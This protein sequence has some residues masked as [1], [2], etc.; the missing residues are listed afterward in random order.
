MNTRHALCITFTFLLA[1]SGVAGADTGVSDERVV[2]PDGPGSMGGI[3]ENA[4]LDPNMGLMRYGVPVELPEGFAGMTPSVHLG[5]SSGSGSSVVGI[6]WDLSLPLIERMSLRGLPEYTTEDEFAV[7]GGEEL[8][9]VGTEAGVRVYRARFEKGFA[10]YQW[11]D[12]GDGSGGYWTAEYP[13][14]RTDFFGADQDGT[15]VPDARVTHPD[16]GVF[17]YHLVATTDLFGHRISYTYQKHGDTALVDTIGWVYSGSDT[18]RYSVRFLYGDR[19]EAVSTCVPGFELVLDQ[20]L[21]GIEVFSN[22]ERIR[23]YELGYEPYSESGGFTRL[24]SVK[25]YGVNDELHPIQFGFGYSRSLGG[26]CESGCEKPYTVDMGTLPGGVDISTGRATLIDINGDALPDVLNTTDKG[27]HRF[28]LSQIGDGGEP[29]F[30]DS[31][32]ESAS[33]EGGSSFVLNAPGVQV[34]DV[35]GDGFTDII[36]SRVGEALCNRG[37]GDWSA[38]AECMA[39]AT[40]PQLQEDEAGDPNPRHVRFMDFDNDKRIDMIR[41]QTGATEV[42]HN[43]GDAFEQ[44]LVQDIGA[45]FDDSNL[46][47][48]DMNGDGLQDPLQV[49]TGGKIRYRL[50]LGF[51]NWTDWI[52]IDLEGIDESALLNARLEDLNG[53]GLDDVVVV[54]ANQLS[55]AL[56]R[57]GQRFDAFVTLTDAEVEGELPEKTSE[58]TVLFADMNGSGSNDIVWITNTGRVR[59]LELFPVKPNLLS[60]IENGIGHVQSIAYGTS[61][62]EQARDRADDPWRYRLPHAMNVVIATDS[63][64]TLTGGEDG[65]GLHQRTEMLYHHGFYDGVEKA[66]RGYAEVEQ[67][68]LADANL[69]SQEPG[70]TFMSFDVGADDPYYNGLLLE[71]RVF[72]GDESDPVPL[73]RESVEYDDCEVA[74]IPGSGLRLPVRYICETGRQSVMQEGLQES[75]WVTT[76]SEQ[77][78]DGYGNV[79]KSS[80]LG[81]IHLGPPESPAECAACSGSGDT[82]GKPC[83]ASCTGDEQYAESEFVQPGD[84]TGGAWILGSPFRQI[85]YGASDGPRTETL[86][87]YDGEPFQGLA[88][89]ILTQGLVSRVTQRVSASS[90]EVIE[91]ARNAHDGHGNVIES[92][93]PNGTLEQTATHR[94]KYQYDDLGLKLTRAQILTENGQ[95]E[96]YALQRDIAYEPLFN[97]PSEATAWMRVVDGS[98]VSARNSTEYRYDNFGRTLKIISPGDTEQA[99]TQ[100]IEYL[101]GDPASRIVVH[102]RTQVGGEPDLEQIRCLDGQGREFQKRTRIAEGSYQVTG[103]TEF[104][105]RGAKVRVYQPYLGTSAECDAEPPDGVLYISLRYDAV[106][107]PVQTTAPDAEI[108]GEA[109]ISRTVYRPLVTLSYDPEDNDPQS[110]AFDTPLVQH[111]D[112]LGRP[113][114]IERYLESVAGGAQPAVV[115]IEYDSL[116][117]LAAYTDPGGNRHTQQYDLLGR[118]IAVDDPNSGTTT[119]TYDSAGNLIEKVDARGATVASSYD[120]AN[121]P[122][123]RWNP[124]AP[125]DSRIE[126]VYDQN[127]DCESCENSEGKLTRV[128]YPLGEGRGR[129]SDDVSYDVRGRTAFTVRTLEGNPFKTVFNYDNASRLV[130]VI[131]P[132]GTSFENSYDDASRLTGIGGVLDSVTYDDRGLLSQAAYA[133][134]TQSAR[135]YDALQRLQTLSVEGGDGAVLQGFDFTRDRVGN[136]EQVA[137]TSH[138][139][140][141]RPSW[142]AGYT[143]DSWYRLIKASLDAGG[144]AEETIDYGFDLLDNIES[145]VSS[146][147]AASRAHVG[148]YAYGSDR[149]NAVTR[150]GERDY[151]YDAAGQMTLRGEKSFAWDY[152]GR[153]TSASSADDDV[154]GQYVYGA[155]QTRVM[156]LEGGGAIHY[157]SPN[158]EVRDGIGTSYA[159]LGRTRIARLQSAD[160]MTKVLPDVAPASDPDGLISAADAWVVHASA[161]GIID[162]GPLGEMQPERLLRAAARRLLLEEGDDRVFL[163]S[164]QLG[165]LTLATNAEGEVVGERAFYPTGEERFS[166][167][168]VD[169]HG[170]TGQQVDES[171]GLVHFEHRYLDTAAGRWISADPA[172]LVA[173]TQSIGRLGESTTAYAYVANNFINRIDPSGLIIKPMSKKKKDI[174]KLQRYFKKMKEAGGVVKKNLEYMERSEATFHFD[175]NASSA[176][177]SAPFKGENEKA[178]KNIAIRINPKQMKELGQKKIVGLAHEMQHAVD[179]AT[180]ETANAL[181]DSALTPAQKNLYLE[182]RAKGAENQ[183]RKALNIEMRDYYFNKDKDTKIRSGEVREWK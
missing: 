57:N 74:E 83:G 73:Q 142:A 165:S 53:D 34:L 85:S 82:F 12:A 10:R 77:E 102:T 72:G 40:L 174:N 36:S 154:L 2:L 167:G 155:D 67:R 63:W 21:E 134:G 178:P 38:S 58:T 179:W 79:I 39:D 8:V 135:T 182:Y 15:A 166:Q 171:S 65:S 75:E 128:T 7:N 24:S 91:S 124:E 137:D 93:D 92:V 107:R 114:C 118:V 141:G 50:N 140:P 157:I 60:R 156:K 148:D 32:V 37:E 18:P 176:S 35:N 80:S 3:G 11:H 22:Q 19:Q 177:K 6:G 28:Y 115:A 47:L 84:E 25:Q 76:R 112:G 41:T 121:R 162:G 51:G 99:P 168:Y 122:S 109:S 160:L 5:Y 113:V 132:D 97:K 55:Y 145:A 61:V 136:L 23:R 17:R 94:R 89:G 125:E 147:G 78:H 71:Q 150:A 105:Q 158:F 88:P 69:D 164:D 106:H 131:H 183:M 54:L 170:F 103:F 108:Y 96:A 14:G 68:E 95:G 173:S 144:D 159:R 181:A 120:G 161:E 175:I 30:S 44:Q 13:D 42:F 129:G 4:D 98:V 101:L 143:H 123:A 151:D 100:D 31:V 81:V 64:V 169:E 153:M 146:L 9:H 49:L 163:G 29:G 87:Y 43:K 110:P 133:N 56:N 20:R 104:N 172:F 90:E 117:Q 26:A 66:F 48:S 127:P 45:V 149:P 130:S 46:Q 126:W 152:M 62:A 16:G 86:T 1:W 70:L 116:G 180:G 138:E 139:R 111:T 59:F 119:F 33:T 27:E 52:E